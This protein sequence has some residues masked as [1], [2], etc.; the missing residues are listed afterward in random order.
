MKILFTKYQGTGNDFILIDNRTGRFPKENIKLIQRLTDR[1]FGI[2]ADGLML[3]E[4][5]EQHDL[6]FLMTYYNADGSQS[7]CGNG[8][9]CAIHFAHSL[10]MI[11]ETT[12][13]ETTDGVHEAFIKDNLVHFQLHDVANVGPFKKHTFVNTGSPHHVEIVSDVTNY[14]VFENGSRIRN[15]ALYA[16]EG[17]NV[18]FM[19]LTDNGIKVRTFERGVEDET[20]SCG[21]GVTAAALAANAL[22]KQ[23]PINIQTLGGELS[24]SFIKTSENQFTKIF[25]AGPATKVF[26]GEI[27]VEF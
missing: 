16:P 14:N 3:V 8:S 6:D 4:G 1:K 15:S 23:S 24:V 27:D 21:T 18:N 2:G 25:L 12:T 5:H 9:R 11:D 26:D 17:T 7:L 10:G 19:E 13:F 22:G 20:L